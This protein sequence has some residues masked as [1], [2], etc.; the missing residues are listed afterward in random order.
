MDDNVAVSTDS[1]NNAPVPLPCASSAGLERTRQPTAGVADV[2]P[3]TDNSNSTVDNGQW[4]EVER[5]LSMKRKGKDILYKIK[6]KDPKYPHSWIP[7]QDVSEALKDNYHVRRT[8]T[9][10]LRK[11]FH[12]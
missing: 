9:G 11:R 4:Y 3:D 1:S 2:F 8:L 7:A 12:K 6:W 10:K 5:I